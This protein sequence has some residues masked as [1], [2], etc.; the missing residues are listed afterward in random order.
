MATHFD[1]LGFEVGDIEAFADLAVRAVEEGEP[2]EVEHGTYHVWRPAEGVELWAQTRGDE[3]LGLHP[4]FDG[5]ARMPVAVTEPRRSRR[6]TKLDG[7]FWAWAA[8]DDPEDPESGAFPFLFELPDRAL[9]DV[10]GFPFAAQAQLTAFADAFGWA[11]DE[12]TFYAQQETEPGFAATSFIPS[13]TFEKP[14]TPDAFFHGTL[15]EGGRRVNDATG[16]P[17]WA[18]HVATLGG[19]LNVVARA[20]DVPEDVPAGAIVSVGGYVMGRVHDVVPMA[21]TA[22]PRRGLRGLFSRSR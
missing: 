16:L 3:M 12:E 6:D 1:N 9:V 8:P 4:F 18:G 5:P 10:P 22:P 21:S 15:V 14:P 11:P 13:G 7:T 17:F 2:L 19:E 20:E